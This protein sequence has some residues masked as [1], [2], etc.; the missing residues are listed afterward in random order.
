MHHAGDV[1]KAIYGKHKKAA[2][3]LILSNFK[4]NSHKM[5]KCTLSVYMHTLTLTHTHKHAP[6]YT[7]TISLF[8]DNLLEIRLQQGCREPGEYDKQPIY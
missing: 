6:V 1:H 8:Q 4:V 2:V 3:L 5:C 7:C